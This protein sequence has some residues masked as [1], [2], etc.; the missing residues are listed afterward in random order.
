MACGS[1]LE[2]PLAE[3][4]RHAPVLE[5]IRATSVQTRENCASCHL[6][7]ICAG[8]SP[9]SSHFA[10]LATR[11]RSDIRAA[12]PYCATYDEL[13]HEMLWEL[14]TAG[15]ETIA[16]GSG[17][18]P[19]RLFNCMDGAGA[20]C[21]RP[22]TVATDHAFEVGT[23]HC[24]CVLEGDVEEGVALRPGSGPSGA[25]APADPHSPTASFDAIGHSCVELLLP[26]S[27][28]VRALAPGQ[29]LK[30]QTDDIAAREDLASWC[31]MT[32]NELLDRIK[33]E[34]IDHYYIRRGEAM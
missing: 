9:C 13:T 34:G 23:Y 28:M 14:G 17:Y 19:P 11:G 29:V 26:M 7:F 1:V 6:K 10:S 27:K 33:A 16:T 15:V 12:E 2:Q 20:K 32:G 18:A 22:N 3:I 21:A 5:E 30:V 4:W 8:G 25:S 31:R 24:V